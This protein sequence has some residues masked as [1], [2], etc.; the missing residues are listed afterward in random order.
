MVH[1]VGLELCGVLSVGHVG[2]HGG[3]MGLNVS[4]LANRSWWAAAGERASVGMH[5]MHI[6]IARRDCRAPKCLFGI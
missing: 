6:C 3:T 1:H 2:G 5:H 4:S